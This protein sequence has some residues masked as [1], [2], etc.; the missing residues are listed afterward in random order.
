VLDLGCGT[1]RVLDLGLATP[2]RYAA[3]DSSQAMLNML[4]L[5]HPTVAA[6]YPM[7]VHDA[8]ERGHFTPGQ[9]DWVFLD[10]SISLSEAEK[11][12]VR[13]IARY[14]LIGV[15]SEEWTVTARQPNQGVTTESAKA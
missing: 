7:D 14:A 15:S 13:T 4:V 11:S 1:G 5:K 12:F 3:L 8:L 9:F 6:V 2:A 10:D